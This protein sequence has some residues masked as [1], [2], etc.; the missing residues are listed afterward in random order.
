LQRDRSRGRV[1]ISSGGDLIAGRR[2]PIVLDSDDAQIV[3]V[4]DGHA[5]FVVGTRSDDK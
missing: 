3:L 2:G 4:T 5:W 1:A